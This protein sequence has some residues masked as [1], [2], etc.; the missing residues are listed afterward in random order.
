PPLPKPKAEPVKSAAPKHPE[1]PPAP[2]SYRIDPETI[3]KRA[4]PK[5]RKKEID[6]K[7]DRS[8]IRKEKTRSEWE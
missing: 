4:L 3:L 1:I 2:G 6:W 5:G 7:K 8:R